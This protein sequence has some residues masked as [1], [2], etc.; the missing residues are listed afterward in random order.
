ML[1]LE[2]PLKP[3]AIAPRWTLRQQLTI[4]TILFLSLGGAALWLVAELFQ[5]RSSAVMA[6]NQTELANADARLIKLFWE[7]NQGQSDKPNKQWDKQLQELSTEALA[8]FPRVEGGFYLL[9]KDRLLGY[10][11]PTHGGA[12]PKKDIPKAE[13]KT[14]LELTRRAT[15]RGLPQ[16]L[17]LQPG[18]DLLVLRAEPLPLWGAV[19]TMKRT[20]LP[21]SKDA[22][23]KVLSILVVLMNLVVGAWTFYI[24]LQLHWGVQRLQQSI[25]AMEEGKAEQIP[26]LRAE[27]G[28]LG[29]AINTMHDRRQ[30]LEQRLRRVERLASLGQL[31]AGV[32]HEV[33]NPLASMRLNLQYTQ[34]QLQ[35]QGITT[36]P[37]CSLLEQI[38]RL[39]QLVR[40]LLYFD[41]NQQQEELVSASLEIVAE[42]SVALLHLRAQEQGVTLVYRAATQTLPLVPLRPRELGQV[43]VNLIL[44]AIQAS[45]EGGQVL[46]GVEQ[47]QDYFVSWVEDRGHGLSPEDRERIF[48]P[49]YSTKPEGTGLGLAIS[50]EIITRQGGYIGLDSEPGCTRFSVYLPKSRD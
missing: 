14:I 13:E 40:R 35:K 11:Y 12:S 33:R 45:P 28:L 22:R 24:A 5:S 27:M 37:I 20:P 16:E 50:H 48:D 18:L 2:I 25:K 39:E 8:A 36:L 26:P 17:V 31:V 30:E 1:Y 15:S 46:V 6:R 43:M 32:A 47:Q 3:T 44:N 19:W 42:E 41:Q 23:Q 7:S 10:A 34:R 38:D 49:F 21:S 4:L 29:E 9:Q